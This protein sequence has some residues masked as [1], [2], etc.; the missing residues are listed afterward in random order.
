MA[1]T[2]TNRCLSY[3]AVS[4]IISQYQ[5]IATVLHC[6]GQ[7]FAMPSG[8]S[9]RLPYFYLLAPMFRRHF[10]PVYR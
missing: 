6:Y 3:Q 5:H 2:L 4:E 1:H 7:Y 8:I 10:L 9:K